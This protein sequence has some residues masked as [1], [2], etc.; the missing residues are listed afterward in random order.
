MDVKNFPK[1]I[2]RF[3]LNTIANAYKV[4]IYDDHVI[5]LKSLLIFD[6]LKVG[7]LQIPKSGC[8]TVKSFLVSKGSIDIDEGVSRQI[9]LHDDSY[10]SL[11]YDKFR[12]Y[13]Y[14]KSKIFPIFTVVRNPYT[15]VLSA[16]LEKIKEVKDTRKDY[17]GDLNIK[18]DEEISFSCFLEKLSSKNPRALD[19]HFMPQSI[20]AN[21]SRFPSIHIGYMESLSET[22]YE[23]SKY[24]D[25]RAHT[26]SEE[27][28]VSTH[29]KFNHSHKYNN[30]K[31]APHSVGAS[32]RKK[33]EEYYGKSEIELVKSIYANDF[34]SFGYS[35]SLEDFHKPGKLTKVSKFNS[36][37]V[38]N[39]KDIN[40][41]K[42]K[43]DM[44]VKSIF[45]ILKS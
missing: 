3:G 16:Y 39:F 25:N 41:F 37:N 7:Y 45:Q 43:M 42:L 8:S 9:A 40:T 12:N 23:L 17:R 35:T 28:N 4:S 5:C 30:L 26:N 22:L 6:T 32:T 27:L 10:F 31:E 2:Y 13:K 14:S 20:I 29:T 1:K 44:F 15:R 21:I 38:E 11:T 24:I 36:E 34:N 33:L 18:T 19:F